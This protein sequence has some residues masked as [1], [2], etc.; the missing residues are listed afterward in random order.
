M[1]GSRYPTD[2]D[3]QMQAVLDNMAARCPEPSFLVG[4]EVTV[5]DPD[6]EATELRLSDPDVLFL[7]QKTEISA[8]RGFM[9]ALGI[10]ELVLDG[11]CLRLNGGAM[12]LWPAGFT[13]HVEDGVVHVRNGA[14]RSIARVGDEIAG[15]GGYFNNRYG[16]C[17]GEIL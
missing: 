9:D 2:L 1:S 10:G 17:P 15:G 8:N 13:P 12:I 16:E 6:T 14:G 3:P 7:R 4:D 5:F 11:Q